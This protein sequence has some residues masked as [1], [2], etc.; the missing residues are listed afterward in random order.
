MKRKKQEKR[1]DVEEKKDIVEFFENFSSKIRELS[2]F[3]RKTKLIYLDDY[4]VA[5]MIEL[6]VAF[7]ISIN[8]LV[9]IK[10]TKTSKLRLIHPS[11]PP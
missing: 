6:S 4:R 8:A 2:A 5:L 1:L 11:N 7:K 10:Q 3:G 9:E